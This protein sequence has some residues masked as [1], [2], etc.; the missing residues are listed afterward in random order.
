VEDLE[1]E[2]GVRA[3]HVIGLVDPSDGSSHAWPDRHSPADHRSWLRDVTLLMPMTKNLRA[4]KKKTPIPKTPEFQQTRQFQLRAGI[5]K[6]MPARFRVDSM[7]CKGWIPVVL[8]PASNPPLLLPVLPVSF[9]I[10]RCALRS[11]WCLCALRSFWCPSFS[12]RV[13]SGAIGM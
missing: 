7:L 6:K 4:V 10:P 11:S 13:S 3:N 12:P 1:C 8:R 2:A 9:P 5:C